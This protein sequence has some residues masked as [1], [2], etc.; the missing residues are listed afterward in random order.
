MTQYGKI[1]NYDSSVG[2]GRITPEKGGDLLAFRKSDL[3]DETT[4]PKPDER[5]GFDVKDEDNGKRYA[6]NLHQQ[7]N[8]DIQQEQAR[9]QQG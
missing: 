1:K 7:G 6:I 9:V 5:Y 4:V 3:K 2:K 8:A